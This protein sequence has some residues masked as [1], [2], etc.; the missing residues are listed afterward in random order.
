[1]SAGSSIEIKNLTVSYDRH[2]AVHHLSGQFPIGKDTAIVGPNG[3]GKS[4]LLRTVA[5]LLKQDEGS[6]HYGP[7]TRNDIAYLPQRAAVDREFPIT[8]LDTVLLGHWRKSGAFLGMGRRMRDKAQEAIETVGLSGLEDRTLDTLS[9]GEFQRTLFARIALQDANVILLD[10]PW[11]AI[12]SQTVRD[13]MKIVGEWKQKGKTVIAVLHDLDQV[14]A[15]FSQTLLLCKSCV[16][17]GKTAEVLTT[18]HLMK[19]WNIPVLSSVAEV[20]ETP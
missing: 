12:D 11:S 10:E 7:Y 18:G 13:L 8:V 2:P 14:K 19:A 6:I 3:A 1:M 17:W 20:C 9:G 5:G 16:A 4:T 15:H